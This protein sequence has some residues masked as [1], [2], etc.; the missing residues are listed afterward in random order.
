MW[1]LPVGLVGIIDGDDLGMRIDDETAT[2]L[3]LPGSLSPV[4]PDSVMSMF[5]NGASEF[6]GRLAPCGL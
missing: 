6:R 5:L 1:V 3:N 4:S 2:A